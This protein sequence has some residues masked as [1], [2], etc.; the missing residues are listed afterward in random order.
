[1]SDC[2]CTMTNERLFY[3]DGSDSGFKNTHNIDPDCPEHGVV[4]MEHARLHFEDIIWKDRAEKAEA[5]VAELQSCLCRLSGTT[6]YMETDDKPKAECMKI[7][8]D[9]IKEVDE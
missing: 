1:M 9:I 7:L 4:A 5:R 8:S 3:P 2:K 6:H